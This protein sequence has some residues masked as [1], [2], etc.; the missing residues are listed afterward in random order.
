MTTM[1]KVT[2]LAE[3]LKSVEKGDKAI[4]KNTE[5]LRFFLDFVFNYEPQLKLII[6]VENGNYTIT[7]KLEL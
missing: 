6:N 3:A 5:D 2:T 1:T 7:K 4:L